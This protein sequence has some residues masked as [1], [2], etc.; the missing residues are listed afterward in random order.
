[1]VMSVVTSVNTVGS[2]KYPLGWLGG[3]LP[4]VNSVAPSALAVVHLCCSDAHKLSLRRRSLRQQCT[5]FD[6]PH[7]LFVLVDVHHRPHAAVLFQWV[8]DLCGKV[9][10]TMSH[11]EMPTLMLSARCLSR[12]RK[13]SAM[14]S[15][16][17]RRLVELQI[18][19]V[20]QNTPNC[21]T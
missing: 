10:S 15:C 17:R 5:F 14:P 19:P 20:V 12:A 16:S 6:V 4:P 8:A 18:C 13:R 2:I 7:D 1:M 9:T 11:H 3:R 21:G